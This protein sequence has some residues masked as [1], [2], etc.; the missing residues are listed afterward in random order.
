MLSLD[1]LRLGGRQTHADQNE[2]QDNSGSLAQ[3]H[4]PNLVIYLFV[5]S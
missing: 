2:T 5:A 1:R 4:A 3:A